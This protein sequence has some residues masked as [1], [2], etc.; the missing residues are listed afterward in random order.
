VKLYETSYF[1]LELARPLSV[2]P[3][4]CHDPGKGM[5]QFWFTEQVLTATAKIKTHGVRS[6]STSDRP[7]ELIKRPYLTFRALRLIR[8]P[9][10]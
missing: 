7:A 6:P 8:V 9:S 5:K 10:D 3:S 1:L 4:V 2:L